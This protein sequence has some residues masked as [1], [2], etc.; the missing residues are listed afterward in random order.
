MEE[1]KPGQIEGVPPGQPGEAPPAGSK[2]AESQVPKGNQGGKKSPKPQQF[3]V[4]TPEDVKRELAEKLKTE[5]VEKLTPIMV[6]LSDYTKTQEQQALTTEKTHEL[7]KKYLVLMEAQAKAQTEYYAFQKELAQKQETFM[8]KA[9]KF[10]KG[11]VYYAIGVAVVL[12]FI[13]GF[14]VRIIYMVNKFDVVKMSSAI[15]V[16]LEDIK[17]VANDAAKRMG[18]ATAEGSKSIALICNKMKANMS[19]YDL[20]KAEMEKK[21]SEKKPLASEASTGQVMVA[22]HKEDAIYVVN[23]TDKAFKVYYVI[24]EAGK[25]PEQWKKEAYLPGAK[26]HWATPV[27]YRGGEVY[28]QVVG[29][30]FVS[31]IEKFPGGTWYWKNSKEGGIKTQNLKDIK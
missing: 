7:Q 31:S 30:D 10:A 4:M 25:K 22:S 3:N 24:Y 21:R 8:G 11:S 13:L 6:R 29:E 27:P 28:L 5:F 9:V 23:N 14:G 17:T 15:K 12:V 26:P 20:A 18:D 19:Q 16:E 1:K 2:P